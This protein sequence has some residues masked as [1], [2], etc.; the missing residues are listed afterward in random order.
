MVIYVPTTI[1][2]REETLDMLRSI[3][4]E[5]K[6]ESLDETIRGL[7]SK[8]KRPKKSYFGKFRGIG[9]FEREEIDRFD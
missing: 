2:V 1:A 8:A 6:A 5:L 7:I 3:K 4:E 9:S